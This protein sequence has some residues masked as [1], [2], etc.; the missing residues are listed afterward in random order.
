MKTC[1]K[2]KLDKPCSDFNK[3]KK[4]SDG[5]DA[6]CRNCNKISCASYSRSEI[7]QLKAKKRN[8]ERYGITVEDYEQILSDQ[9]GVCAICFETEDHFSR[10]VVDHNHETGK[11]RGLLCNNCNRALGLF[12]DTQQR[13]LS[14]AQY[15]KRTHG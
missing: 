12:K 1:A 8:I 9:N 5:L 7:G 11:V 10:L 6:W 2:C 3:R 15:L 4:A 13:L 14:A